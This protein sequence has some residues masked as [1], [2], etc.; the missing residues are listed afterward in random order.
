M[1]KIWYIKVNSIPEGPFSVRE[2][3][4]DRRITPNT[5]VWREGFAK[6]VAIRYVVELKEVFAD[7]ESPDYEKKEEK[8]FPSRIPDREELA[9]DLR[10][11]PPRFFWLLVIAIILIYLIIQFLK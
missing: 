4:R 3:K 8:P 11:D 2:L 5:L 1:E 7:D 10:I 6:W 9:L